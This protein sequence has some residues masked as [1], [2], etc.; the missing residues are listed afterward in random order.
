MRLRIGGT[1][2]AMAPTLLDRFDAAFGDGLE[3][4]MIHHHRRRLRRRGQLNAFAPASDGLYATPAVAP[5]EGNDLQILIDGP[6]A[7]P[8][9][10]E[11]IQNAKRHERGCSSPLGRHLGAGTRGYARFTELL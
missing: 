1:E 3:R 6:N 10:A 5:R 7:L 9:M 2:S 8:R 4:A 11:A